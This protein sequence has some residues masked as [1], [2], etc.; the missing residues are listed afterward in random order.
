MPFSSQA[1]A[2]SSLMA[3]DASLMSVSPSQ[4]SAKPSPVPGPSTGPSTPGFAAAKSSRTI[5]LMG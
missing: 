3:R 5:E 1:A 2:S 4:N